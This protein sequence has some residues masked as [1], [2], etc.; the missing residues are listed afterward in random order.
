MFRPDVPV[1]ILLTLATHDV[2]HY[3]SSVAAWLTKCK[4]YRSAKREGR[5]SWERRAV[6]PVLGRDSKKPGE[7][8]AII[9]WRTAL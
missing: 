5:M 8:R 2:G 4:K 9:R 3:M 7:L 1:E 6:R